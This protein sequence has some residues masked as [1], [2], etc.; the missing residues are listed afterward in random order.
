[1]KRVYQSIVQH[2][3]KHYDQMAFISGPRQVGK[4]TL[5]KHFQTEASDFLYLN[6]DR[7]EDRKRILEGFLKKTQPV[8]RD[9]KPILVLDEIHKYKAWKNYLK[10]F[11]DTENDHWHIIVTGSA[12][13]N[14]YRKGGDSLMGRY[15]LY[16]MHPLSIGELLKPDFDFS[17][18][19]NPISMPKRIQKDQLE[20]LVEFGGFPEPLLRQDKLFYQRWQ[21]LRLAQMFREDIRSL[22]QI[23]DVDQLELLVL[24]LQHQTGQLVNYHSLASNIRVSDQTIRRW[25]SLLEACFYCFTIKPW[26][27]NITNA[28]IKMPKIYLTDW[29]LVADQGPRLENFV[30]CH[31]FKAVQF[32]NDV[33]LGQYDLFFIRDKAKNEVDFLITQKRIPWLMVEVKASYKQ[34]L[35]KSLYHFKEILK[36]PHTLQIVADLPYIEKDCF[37]LKQPT[38]VPLSTFLSQ[39]I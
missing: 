7:L 3:L 15:F 39:L 33:G 12:K 10:G 27:K 32:W 18:S 29:S 8:L 25:I 14:I 22:S 28:L 11:Y 37:S 30:A 23:A 20:T 19:Q 36:V 24:H 26:A 31:L 35:S 38:I 13:L 1:M 9:Q 2:H 21:N 16:R 6:W 34:G 17:H 5:T 4:T